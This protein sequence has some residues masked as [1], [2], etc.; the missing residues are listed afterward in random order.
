MYKQ[1]LHT[2]QMMRG[3]AAIMIMY[4]HFYA[5][6]NINAGK[7]LFSI[8]VSV[9]PIAHFLFSKGFVGVD[10]FFVLSGFIMFY[11]LRSYSVT[12]FLVSRYSRIFPVY[13]VAL[14]FSLVL[15][16]PHMIHMSNSI[17]LLKTL[18]LIP[19]SGLPAPYYGANLVPVA[20]TLSYEIYFYTV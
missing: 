2:L 17:L 18:F 8:N 16:E 3:V 5:F 7:N 1:K 11:T 19:L 20:W 15:L 12:Q 13:I 14:V 10:L 4:F 9:Y 6:F